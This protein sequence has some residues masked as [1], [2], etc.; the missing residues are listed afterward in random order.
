MK[1]EVSEHNDQIE[2]N[3][4]LESLQPRMEQARLEIIVNGL[5]EQPVEVGQRLLMNFVEQETNSGTIYS[6]ISKAAENAPLALFGEHSLSLVSLCIKKGLSQQTIGEIFTRGLGGFPEEI[7]KRWPQANYVGL[8][9][10]PAA[11]AQLALDE[12]INQIPQIYELLDNKVVISNWADIIHGNILTRKMSVFA[13]VLGEEWAKRPIMRRARNSLFFISNLPFLTA[14]VS[15][16]TDWMRGLIKK[17]AENSPNNV[18]D[19]VAEVGQALEDNPEFRDKI[20]VDALTRDENLTVTRAGR[21]VLVLKTIEDEELHS[22]AEEIIAAIIEDKPFVS[23]KSDQ[24]KELVE[25]F[26]EN[27]EPYLTAFRNGIY[28]QINKTWILITAFESYDDYHNAC[29][30]DE[31]GVLYFPKPESVEETKEQILPFL[32]EEKDVLEIFDKIESYLD[33][34]RRIRDFEKKKEKMIKQASGIINPEIQNAKEELKNLRPSN[35]ESPKPNK[36]S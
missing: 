22:Q 31:S 28:K 25:A 30:R 21:S 18:I 29:I 8:N 4:F 17:V 19:N 16:E 24:L 20:I 27:A 15:S 2:F 33:V 35:D 32:G 6:F 12:F 13:S 5:V 11:P 36:A 23:L 34:L 7:K 14:A 10:G 26:G 1:K 3:K 9:E